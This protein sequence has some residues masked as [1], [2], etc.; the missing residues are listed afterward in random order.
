M[1]LILLGRFG[2]PGLA[3]PEP[4][5]RDRF[6][7][8][9][10]LVLE[11]GP[12]EKL[13]TRRQDPLVE[14]CM[15]HFYICLYVFSIIKPLS[16]FL[17]P[18][19]SHLYMCANKFVTSIT[20]ECRMVHL[21]LFP[22]F[23]TCFCASRRSLSHLDSIL[24]EVSSVAQNVA[25]GVP[26]AAVK[27]ERW[28]LKVRM[29]MLPSEHIGKVLVEMVYYSIIPL[30]MY[31]RSVC[32]GFQWFSSPLSFGQVFHMNPLDRYSSKCLW[33][34]VLILSQ[35]QVETKSCAGNMDTAF[36]GNS[37]PL[38]PYTCAKHLLF[39]ELIRLLLLI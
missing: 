11:E 9:V 1:C 8:V 16:F 19:S 20:H 29:D 28:N 23:L 30:Y 4:P 18:F 38:K 7:V 14:K 21:Q 12:R 35:S 22:S 2:P 31:I 27:F 15:Y 33:A 10:D 34:F 25:L 26:W 5:F 32:F 6:Q 13:A 39:Q 3:C 24:I 37:H 17:L 36:Q